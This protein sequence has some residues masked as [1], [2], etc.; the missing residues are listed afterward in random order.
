MYFLNIFI[1]FSRRVRGA[2]ELVVL[3]IIVNFESNCLVQYVMDRN[4]RFFLKFIL[5]MIVL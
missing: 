2:T 5:P 1:F 3:A 4:Q